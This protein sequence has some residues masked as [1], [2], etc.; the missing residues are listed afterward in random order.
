MLSDNQAASGD[1]RLAKHLA[2][3]ERTA[4][5]NKGI[6]ESN[7]YHD[8]L[9]LGPYPIRISFELASC[10]TTAE[11]VRPRASVVYDTPNPACFATG[12]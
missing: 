6:P 5:F 11:R 4:R 10:T 2:C 9:T 7:V 8:S 12:K 3:S 1:M